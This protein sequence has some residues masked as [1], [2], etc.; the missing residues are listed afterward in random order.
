MVVIANFRTGIPMQRTP[1]GIFMIYIPTR[2]EATDVRH[3]ESSIQQNM[4]TNGFPLE[5]SMKMR[6][7]PS[8]FNIGPK[9]SL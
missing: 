9:G 3:G 5:K 6:D 2:I 4:Q 7:I 8:F 1:F